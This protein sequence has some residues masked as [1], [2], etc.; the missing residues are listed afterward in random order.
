MTL[1]STAGVSLI[2]TRSKGGQLIC[3]LLVA[4]PVGSAVTGNHNRFD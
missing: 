2:H 1:M 3:P 4:F